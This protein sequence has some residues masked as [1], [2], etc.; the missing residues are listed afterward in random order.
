MEPSV[1]KEDSP[2]WEGSC[3]KARKELG[4]QPTVGYDEGIR[5]S[6]EWCLAHG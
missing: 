4:W 5:R 2:I 1:P 6:V 3:E